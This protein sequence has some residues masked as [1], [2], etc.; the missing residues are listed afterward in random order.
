MIFEDCLVA[1]LETVLDWDDLPDELYSDAVTSQAAL[2]ACVGTED[3]P[4]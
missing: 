3:I 4:G 2:L 1:A